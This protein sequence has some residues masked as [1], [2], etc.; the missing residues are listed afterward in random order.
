[1]KPLVAA[2]GALALVAAGCTDLGSDNTRITGS[3]VMSIEARDVGSFDR[4]AVEGSGEVFI[5]VGPATSLE[6]EAEDNVMAVLTTEIRNGRLVLSVEE[7]NSLRNVEIPIYRI[8]TPDLAGVSIAGSG[9]VVVD[10]VDT[11][12]FTVDI[13]GSVYVQPTGSAGHISVSISGSGDYDGASLSAAT[14]EVSI[15]GSGAVVVN[16]TDAL[17]VSIAGSGDVV[18]MGNPTLTQSIDGDGRVSQR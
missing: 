6:I 9:D 18:Y 3:G 2:L 17:D 5:E 14:A 4:L 11:T 13:A 15:A 1:M 10:G 12:E 16:A 7:G 8:T